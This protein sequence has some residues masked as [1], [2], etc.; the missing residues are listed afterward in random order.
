MSST[1]S[2]GVRLAIQG[3]MGAS[4]SSFRY[5]LEMSRAAEALGCES[6]WIPD[7]VENAR[8]DPSG[9]ILEHW[10]TATAIGALTRRVRIGGHCLSNVFRHP[11]LVAKMFATLD[12]VTDGRA[13]LAM[14][15]GWFEQ[16]A[17]AY[18]F[19]W[20][21]HTTRVEK[22]REALRIIKALWTQKTVT[23]HGRFYQLQGAFLEPKPVQTPHPPIW[24]AGDSEA[25]QS[26][27]A[28]LADV[29]FMYAKPVGK[30]DALTDGMRRRTGREIPVALSFV[31]L[32]GKSEP[33]I[34]RWAER[35]VEERRHRFAKPPTVEDVLKS[36]LYGSPDAVVDKIGQLLR[37]GVRYVVVQPMPPLEGLRFFGEQVLPRFASE[38]SHA[39][40]AG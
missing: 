19:P 40:L 26:V 34:V 13:I 9:P 5:A 22:L 11:G 30:V 15:S 10:T 21:D 25:I 18:G 35:Y 6:I 4:S 7:H 33:E 39:P 27:V 16:E 2:F 32:T 29:W 8:G 28:E 20:E 17:K 31:L 37:L 14:G 12:E 36:S 24:V 1:V 38:D 23:Y 3:E